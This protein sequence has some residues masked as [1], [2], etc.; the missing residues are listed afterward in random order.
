ME[1]I[2]I[3]TTVSIPLKQIINKNG[4][5]YVQVCRGK[6]SCVYEQRVGKKIFSYEVFEIVIMQEKE[7][8]GKVIPKRERFPRDEDF[9][10]TAWVYPTLERAMQKFKELEGKY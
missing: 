6:R 2:E 1:N 9:G 4:Y 10:Y 7:I 3:N 5:K 8:M